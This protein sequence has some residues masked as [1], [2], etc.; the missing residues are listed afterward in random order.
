MTTKKHKFQIK[1]EKL[2]ESAGISINGENPWDMKVH[3]D[4]LYARVFAEGS[5][6][7][8][9]AYMDGWWDS[10]QL[11]ELISRCMAAKLT[12]QIP[13][14]LKTLMLYTQARFANRQ[15]KS[16]AF[17]AAD[18]HYDLGNDLF[19]GTFDS[20]LT[21][22]CG[23]WAEADELDASQDAKL[24]LICRKIGLKKGD[25][26]FDI[27]CGWGAFMGYAAEK[28]GAICEGV[29]VS[30]EQVAYIHDR[31]AD[32]PVTATLADY[33]DAQGQFDHI[34]SMGM[35]EHV[36]PKNYRTYFETAHRLLKENGFFLL[37]TIGGQGS[38]DQIDPWLDKYIF[39]NG[40]LPSL[41][42]VGESIEGLFMVE[43]L[44][45][46]GADYDKTLMAWHHKFESNWPTL[47]QN[48]DERFRRMWN[49][50]LLTCAGGFRAR[51]IQLWQF[52]LAKRGI[53]GGYTSVR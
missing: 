53:P 5:L 7:L 12:E 27:G 46:F 33:R 39:P 43:D 34:V 41:K 32:L 10:D 28:Y 4:R 9:E 37:H 23:Y 47:S 40:V 52:V 21:G 22:S 26:V 2:L 24:D 31:Y 29:T 15:S 17:I 25:R 19:A 38:T 11:D 42:Q 8:G 50:Y 13:R 18:V 51:H 49:Y 35:F 3:D 48:Y 44:H 30:K 1:S 45:N 16:R 6:G 36:G 20:R 14:N